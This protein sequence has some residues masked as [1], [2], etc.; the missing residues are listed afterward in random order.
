[1]AKILETIFLV[2]IS[3]L[4]KNTNQET[5]PQEFEDLPTTLEEVVSGLV[6]NDCI[7]EVEKA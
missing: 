5:S 6:S 3:Q 7:V 2:K 4:V 1:M